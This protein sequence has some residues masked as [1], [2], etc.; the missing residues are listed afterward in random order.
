MPLPKLSGRI[1]VDGVGDDPAWQSVP[2]LPFTVYLPVFGSAAT[3]R[4]DAR[5]AYDADALYVM[6]DA[7]GG[8][9]R[10][11]S[12]ELDDSRRRR[13]RRFSQRRDRSVR[14]R[15]NAVGFSTTPG[16]QRVD[17]TVMNDAQTPG[18]NSPAWNGVWDLAVRRGADGFHAE[19]R[20][21]FRRCVSA[22]E[23]RVEFG[24][25]VNR[26]TAHSNERVVFPAIEPSSGTALWRPSLMQRVSA[27]GV[28]AI[29][30]VR[31][32]PYAVADVRAARA[33]P[34]RVAVGEQHENGRGR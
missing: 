13:T 14:R 8:A 20:I 5:I 15:K 21:P 24:L 16:G 17:W 3:E 2:V 12:G 30:S 22:R 9:P 27:E 1:T 29:R 25:S 6:I 33:R 18:F 28:N 23:G 4:T 26:I 7:A 11:H 31:L 10:P 34:G 19:F 32:T